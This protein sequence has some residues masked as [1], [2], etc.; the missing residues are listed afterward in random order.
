[1]GQEAE[2]RM[3]NMV[4]L[5]DKK[6]DGVHDSLSSR[7][8]SVCDFHDRPAMARARLGDQP[9]LLCAHCYGLLRLARMVIDEG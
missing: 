3:R 7:Q 9:H 2:D 1:M 8:V 6:T 5:L 4:N